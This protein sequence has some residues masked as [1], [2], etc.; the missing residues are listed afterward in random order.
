MYSS[1]KLYKSSSQISPSPLFEFEKI[2]YKKIESH[3]RRIVHAHDLRMVYVQVFHGERRVTERSNSLSG[4]GLFQK[5]ACL[6]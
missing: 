3:E 2:L 4:A 6:I 5:P 1:S